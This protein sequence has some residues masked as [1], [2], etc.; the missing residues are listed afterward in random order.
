MTRCGVPVIIVIRIDITC[1]D[2]QSYTANIQRDGGLW[3]DR[4]S[5]F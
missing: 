1:I 5:D 4:H 3:G 2:I